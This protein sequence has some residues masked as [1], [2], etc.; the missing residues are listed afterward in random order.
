MCNKAVYN[1][2]PALALFPEWFMSQE[3]CNKVV[4]T[5]SSVI[6]FVPEYYKTQ[7]NV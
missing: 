6:K 2:P 1:Y 4:N 3:M 7:T 5:Y